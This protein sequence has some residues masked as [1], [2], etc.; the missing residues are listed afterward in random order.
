MAKENNGFYN[1]THTD[2]YKTRKAIQQKEYME[3]HPE[4][5]EKMIQASKGKN[6]IKKGQKLPEEW[7]INM[8]G[9]RPQISGEK[10]P[11]YGNYWTEEQKE[12]ARMMSTGLNNH[13]RKEIVRLS[14]DYELL[15]EYNLIKEAI[16][17]G[18]T[19]Y[20]IQG[21][22]QG[23][24]KRGYYKGFRWMYKSDYEKLKTKGGD[25]YVKS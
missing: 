23:R 1:H 5:L 15:E 21:C 2:E 20:G 16:A 24:T 11:N 9:P 3:S 22:L 7:C 14:L 13:H 17:Q 25:T 6:P 8:R 4:Q 19:S 18:Y 10:N 12:E